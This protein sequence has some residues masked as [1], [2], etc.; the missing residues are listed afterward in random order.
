[1]WS[2]ETCRR[3]SRIPSADAESG[4]DFRADRAGSDG[5]PR[6]HVIMHSL[7]AG[8]SNGDANFLTHIQYSP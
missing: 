4:Y 2:R 3:R 7:N 6:L 5:D 8:M 1:M